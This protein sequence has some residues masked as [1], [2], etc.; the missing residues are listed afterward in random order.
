M[1]TAV[2]LLATPLVMLVAS[3]EAHAEIAE[4]LT[5]SWHQGQAPVVMASPSQGWWKAM[6]VL[7]SAGGN[8]HSADDVVKVTTNSAD[9]WVLSGSGDPGDNIS[10]T[11]TCAWWQAFYN[12]VPNIWYS[13]IWSTTQGPGGGGWLWGTDAFCF[14]Q[15]VGGV[16]DENT[17]GFQP[18]P[19]QNWAWN[20]N[21]Y[22][23]TTPDWS[24]AECFKFSSSTHTV[25]PKILPGSPLPGS[26]YYANND[27]VALPAPAQALCALTAVWGN[28]SSSTSSFGGIVIDGPNNTQTLQS[29]G[30]LTVQSN[31]IDFRVP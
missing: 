31:C 18:N 29:R 27:V 1:R 24:A 12:D 9:Y 3:S 30:D 28:G 8:F 16:I 23:N 13:G 25:Y 5:Y 17:V 19:G 6:C 26:V 7:T 10:A 15:G 20:V 14:L 2:A 21:G 22:Y 4:Y 11:A